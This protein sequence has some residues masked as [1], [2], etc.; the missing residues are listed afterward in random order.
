MSLST[1]KK[2]KVDLKKRQHLNA[3]FFANPNFT[4]QT[5]DI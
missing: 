1:L 2:L 4:D 5:L 3:N